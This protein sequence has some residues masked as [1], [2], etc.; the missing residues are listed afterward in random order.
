[1]YCDIFSEAYASDEY[2]RHCLEVLFHDFIVGLPNVEELSVDTAD[3]YYVVIDNVY[4]Y[5]ANDDVD[6]LTQSIQELL[7][8]DLKQK[9]SKQ[10]QQCDGF[11]N[12]STSKYIRYI[13]MYEDDK[14]ALV[15]VGVTVTSAFIVNV[16]VHG[17]SLPIEHEIWLQIPHYCP[18]FR[19][20]KTILHIVSMYTVCPGNPDPQ[21]QNLV[22]DSDLLDDAGEQKRAGYKEVINGS[23]IRSSK[24]SLLIKNS[25]CN[26]CSTYRRTLSKALWRE[27]DRVVTSQI[28]WVTS[29]KGNERLS[30]AEKTEKLKQLRK[31]ATSLELEVD[32]LQR[33]LKKS[34]KD[35][36]VQLSETDSMEMRTFGGQA[37][38]PLGGNTKRH[39]QLEF[40]NNLLCMKSRRQ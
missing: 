3:E 15:K 38:A 40:D 12:L 31:Y 14:N 8:A 11:S 20:V 18:T 19:H 33:T 30:S 25:R 32:K 28:N 9:C 26:C 17:L 1:M 39:L 29:R 16:V 27:K 36:S 22:P 2:F 37:L 21:Y 23:T 34:T 10:L 5:D 6:Q 35:N 24:C 13:Q 7:F 4:Q